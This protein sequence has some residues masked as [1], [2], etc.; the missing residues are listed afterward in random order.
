MTMNLQH[1][2]GKSRK[3]D[4]LS[5]TG[6]ISGVILS[7][8]DEDVE[9]LSATV[10]T[11]RRVGVRTLLDPQTYIYSTSPAGTAR[12][13]QSQG[14]AYGT[15]HWSQD[16]TRVSQQVRDVA[17]A[18]AA[19]GIS[20]VMIA[21][22]CKQST[23][24]DIWTPLSLQFARTAAKDWGGTRTI[25]SVVIE[26]VAFDDWNS[27]ADW[28]DVA[29]TLDVRGFYLL[30]DRGRRDYPSA[31]WS[32][33][34]LENLM[35]LIYNLSELNEF[36]VHWGYSDID[37]L[38]GVAAGG[39]SMAAGW[40][41][42]LRQFAISKWQPSDARGG[43]AA[44][45]VY[46]PRLWAALRAEGEVGRILETEQPE[47]LLPKGFIGRFADRPLAEWGRVEAQMLHL[48]LLGRSAKKLSGMDSVTSRL[49]AVGASL[50]G[51]RAHYRQLSRQNVLLPALYQ[52]RVESYLEAVEGFRGSESL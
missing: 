9:T 30:V 16:A 1:G 36:E 10:A 42:S 46:M 51:A 3:I 34:R 43:L 19:I 15:M 44:P 28:L 39:T 24:S 40:H 20:E 2:Y 35:R 33:L 49:D 7:S 14:I 12:H 45:R 5:A 4:E 22:A 41:Y 25:A 32:P 27:V 21:P 52:A 8:G 26:D 11:C 6:A 48:D 38:L 29:T 37:G 31:P 18:N 13:H 23:F 47:K 17:A 50:E